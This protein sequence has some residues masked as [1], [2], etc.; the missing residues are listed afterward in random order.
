VK[1]VPPGNKPTPGEI[2]ECNAYLAAELATLG[3]VRVVL[4][5]GAIAHGAVLRALELRVRDLPF[6]HGGQH[7]LPGGRML[8][9]SYHCSR[10]NT[11]TRRL[12]PAMFRKIFERIAGL[13]AHA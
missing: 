5:L 8:V 1:C 10:Y 3:S 9:D 13:C 2:A 4:A 7:E 6:A 12:T 11:Q